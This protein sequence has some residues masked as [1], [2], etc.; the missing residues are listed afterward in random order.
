MIVESKQKRL[1]VNE[2]DEKT[3]QLYKLLL[4]RI[5]RMKF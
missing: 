1:M 2:D 4:D 3:V 5:D